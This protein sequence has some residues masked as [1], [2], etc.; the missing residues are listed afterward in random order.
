MPDSKFAKFTDNLTTP[1]IDAYIMPLDDGNIVPT[2][3]I[4]VGGPGDI[5]VVMLKGNDVP[6]TLKNVPIGMW[7]FRIKEVKTAGTTA[8]DIVGLI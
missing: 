2:R 8:T 7:P 5:T 6:I 3:G 4:W 1:I